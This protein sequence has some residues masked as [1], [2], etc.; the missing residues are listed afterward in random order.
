MTDFSAS[1]SMDFLETILHEQPIIFKL[2][3]DQNGPVQLPTKPVPPKLPRRPPQ[4]SVQQI[5]IPPT[6]KLG[7]SKA[8]KQRQPQMRAHPRK[9]NLPRPAPQQI[10]N[11]VRPVVPS[12]MKDAPKNQVRSSSTAESPAPSVTKQAPSVA[13]PP[14]APDTAP[15]EKILERSFFD[16]II[17]GSSP[18]S[19]PC[20]SHPRLG[21]SRPFVFLGALESCLTPPTSLPCPS[22][23][24]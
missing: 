7:A 24:F 17:Q 4:Q 11:H 6:K 2:L 20:C 23:T 14:A 13:S 1:T 10:Q 5:R 15:A 8:A 9:Q 19:I 3:F 22:P 21:G 18:C 12:N 16:A